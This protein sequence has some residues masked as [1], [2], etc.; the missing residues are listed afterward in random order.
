M[1]HRRE[2][3]NL[4][5]AGI[6]SAATGD[7]LASCTSGQIDPAKIADL[8]KQAC[9]IAVP[10]TTIVQV[11]NASIGATVQSIVDLLCSGYH[12]TLAAHAA[13]AK[14]NNLAA[15]AAPASGAEVPYDVI[16]NGKVIH[17]VATKM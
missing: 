1:F 13:A 10:V 6:S 11:V 7:L 5:L 9:G 14:S 4:V 12:A 8:L 3:L 2:V 16:V 17:I 15:P